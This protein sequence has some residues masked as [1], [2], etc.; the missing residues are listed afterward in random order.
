MPVKDSNAPMTA[1]AL[2]ELDKHVPV[3]TN[4]GPPHTVQASLSD[5]PK[6]ILPILRTSSPSSKAKATQLGISQQQERSVP[7]ASR[8]PSQTAQDGAGIDSLPPLK[9]VVAGNVTGSSLRQLR[10]THIAQNGTHIPT[11]DIAQESIHPGRKVTKRKPSMKKQAVTGNAPVQPVKAVSVQ[12]PATS[13]AVAPPTEE[14]QFIDAIWLRYKRQLD[15]RTIEQSRLRYADAELVRAREANEILRTR[16]DET[17]RC[18]ARHK[19]ELGEN[20]LKMAVWQTK[21]GKLTEHISGLSKDHTKLNQDSICIQTRQE[22]ISKD[23]TN[24][25]V[26]MKELHQYVKD[27]K[28]AELTDVKKE[29]E[30]RI[31]LLEQTV[32]NQERQ[33][34]EDWDLL[35]AERERNIRLEAEMVDF[36]DKH[37]E[38]MRDVVAH[39]QAI[40][41]QL[42]E[43][44]MKREEHNVASNSDNDSHVGT[45]LEECANLIKELRD[46]DSVTPSDFQKLNS[47]VRNY[48][49]Q[50]V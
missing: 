35:G 27:G 3:N 7:E 25:D 40:S 41:T 46:S 14:V 28:L 30:H 26:S 31:R 48:A 22:E 43:L 8:L 24:M 6:D 9:K 29:A 12:D 17:Q 18:A 33:L 10:P 4:H 47:S 34:D 1:T 50:S 44:L 11:M 15:E 32:E 13:I 37:D 49:E 36:S 19:A 2:Q 20:K 16:L 39:R 5:I 42:S 45:Q 23:K 21:L 38:L